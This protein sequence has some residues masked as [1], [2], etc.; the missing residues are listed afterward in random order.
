MQDIEDEKYQSE[1]NTLKESVVRITPQR[2]AVLEYLL[3]S[4][5]LPTADDIYKALKGKFPNMSV[6][7]AY[8]NLRILSEI[9]LVSELTYEDDS[10]RYDSN[11][12][13]QYHIVCK[14]LGI[15][16]DFDYIK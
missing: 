11:I 8:N 1:I 7:T 15:V 6:A 5:I 3:A 16:V 12:D 13:D 9:G 4:M 2:H 10:S 14:Y